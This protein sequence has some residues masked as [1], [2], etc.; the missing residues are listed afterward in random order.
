MHHVAY[1]RMTWC[2]RGLRRCQV[3]WGNDRSQH[4]AGNCRSKS[5]IHTG[6]WEQ[7]GEQL[8][9][10]GSEETCLGKSSN[11]LAQNRWSE[12]KIKH[13][14]R[15]QVQFVFTPGSLFNRK[16]ES[17]QFLQQYFKLHYD[18]FD[19]K[20]TKNCISIK[21]LCRKS[22]Y[23]CVL[24]AMLTGATS[25]G[26][27]IAFS[28]RAKSRAFLHCSGDTWCSAWWIVDTIQQSFCQ[29][30]TALQQFVKTHSFPMNVTNYT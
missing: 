6:F 2:T 9:Y 13:Y 21:M 10:W 15:T 1:C 22:L 5:L 23:H 18:E 3:C 17:T 16:M 29:N 14:S 25:I 27:I 11:K 20:S 12:L 28:T 7:P 19:P 8:L 26:E 30:I 24:F 4:G